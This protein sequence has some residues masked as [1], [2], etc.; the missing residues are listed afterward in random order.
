[1]QEN[2]WLGE[3][4]DLTRFPVP[5]LH[6]QDGGRYFGTYGLRGTDAGR[7]LGQLVGGPADAG[8]P[9]HPGGSDHSHPAHRHHPRAVAPPGRPAM[10][11]GAPPAALAAAGMPLPEGQRSRLRGRPGRRA[12]GGGA[13][14]DQRPVGSGQC[15]DRPGG[16]D[17]PRRNRAGRPD[18]R[19]P[20]LFLPHRQAAAAVPRPCAELPRPADPADLRRRHATGGKPHHLG[21]HD[22]R[23]T[24]GR[25][26]ERRT[27]GG[28]GLVSYEAATCWAVLS[29]DVQRLA[30]LAPT[31]RPSPYGSPRPSSAR[32]PGTWCRS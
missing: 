32:M 18:G 27:A 25:G 17:Q 8:G 31:P 12:G 1:M 29:I 11:L 30:A 22:F 28:H 7:Q 5:L 19:I 16:R 20:R 3:Q 23:A 14:A 15:R 24:A 21:H 4:V 6:E 9:Q 10:A 26:A 13:H 2:V